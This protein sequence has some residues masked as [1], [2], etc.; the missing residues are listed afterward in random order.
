MDDNS[1]VCSECGGE[2]SESDRICPHC[3]AVI[4][5]TQAEENM[6]VETA[7]MFYSDVDAEIAKERLEEAGIDCYLLGSSDGSMRPSLAFSQGIRLMVLK[8]DLEKAV[9]YLK[10]LNIIE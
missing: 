9:E 1:F 2:I 6:E 3:G 7:A 10:G 5:A 4:E 8:K